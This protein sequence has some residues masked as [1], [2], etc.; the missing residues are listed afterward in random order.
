MFDLSDPALVGTGLSLGTG[1][2]CANCHDNASNPVVFAVN[3]F[4][5]TPTITGLGTTS[6]SHRS[7][8]DRHGDRRAGTRTASSTR[9][10]PAADAPGAESTVA[11]NDANSCKACHDA[12]SAAIGGAAFPHN[13]VDAAGASVPKTDP[14]LRARVADHRRRR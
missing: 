1:Y 13:Y 4:G 11:F 6:T 14:R 5:A 7:P 12:Q 9:T 8:R 3:T 2:L 10:T